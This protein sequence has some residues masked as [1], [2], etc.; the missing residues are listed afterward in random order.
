VP[1]AL[2][3]ARFHAGVAAMIVEVCTRL[4][5]GGA[6]ETVGLTGGVF[7]NAVLVEQAAA[8]LAIAGFRVVMHRVVPPNDGGLALG[9]AVFGRES[10]SVTKPSRNEARRCEANTP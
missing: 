5:A 8:A 3:A 7:Q 10:V 4:R 1:P 2:I 9:Q 6:G